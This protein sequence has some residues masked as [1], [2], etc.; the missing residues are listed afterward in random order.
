MISHADVVL[1]D[2]DKEAYI[3]YVRRNGGGGGAGEGFTNFSK[4][5]L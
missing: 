3:K 1:I 2:D 4:K 5:I